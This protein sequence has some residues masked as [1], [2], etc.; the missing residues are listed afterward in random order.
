MTKK[1]RLQV[2]RLLKALPLKPLSVLGFK[3]SLV[4]SGGIL[5]ENL[6]FAGEILDLDAPTGGY[7]LQACWTTGY[8]AGV[9]A[10]SGV[11]SAHRNS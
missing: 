1:E 10:A 9:S 8:I 4:T 11:F 6:Y 3:W 2:L 7:N 5:V